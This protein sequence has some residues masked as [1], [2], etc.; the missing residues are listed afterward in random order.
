MQSKHEC[1]RMYKI[2]KYNLIFHSHILQLQLLVEFLQFGPHIIHT[3]TI[4]SHMTL[5]SNY[6]LE[7]F[8]ECHINIIIR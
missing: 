7:H 2:E 5:Q 8:T 4:Q 1:A 6:N 3:G